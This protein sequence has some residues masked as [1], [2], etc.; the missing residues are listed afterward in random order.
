VLFVGIE[1]TVSVVNLPVPGSVLPIFTLFIVPL[2]IGLIVN[3][4]GLIVNALGLIV[5]PPVFVIVLAVNVVNPPVDGDIFPIATL[6][7]DPVTLEVSVIVPVDEIATVPFDIVVFPLTV[8]FVSVPT[9][10]K[11]L[12]IV[13]L[14]SDMPLAIDTLFILNNPVILTLPDVSTLNPG[15]ENPA[16]DRKGF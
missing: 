1:V 15:L 5:N 6:F 7:I 14:G 4:L 16:S 3:A 8:R 13:V 9:L 12:K 11:L 2:A 10:V